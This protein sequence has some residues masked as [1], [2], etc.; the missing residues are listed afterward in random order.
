MQVRLGWEA[1]V[2]TNGFTGVVTGQNFVSSG[3]SSYCL[4]PPAVEN[5][6]MPV[7]WVETEYVAQGSD[8]KRGEMVDVKFKFNLG[9]S[10]VNRVN[11]FKGKITA[12]YIFLSGGIRYEVDPGV[13]E[14]GNIRKV[15][16]FTE[17]EL[18]LSK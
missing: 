6:F 2:T 7:E 11:K 4:M 18:Q 16:Y 14:D 17:A 1:K 10:V 3:K 9:D 5:K 12:Q 8:V 13:D 15:G